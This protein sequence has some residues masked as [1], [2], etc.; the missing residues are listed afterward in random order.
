MAR[1][2]QAASWPNSNVAVSY[3]YMFSSGNMKAWD[4]ST[5]G[6]GFDPSMNLQL[7][8]K[9][10]QAGK[11]AL[12]DA[13]AAGFRFAA[14]KFDLQRRV[15]L[16]YLDLALADENLRIQQANVQLLSVLSQTAQARMQAGGP[17]QDL[18][19]IQ[20]AYRLAEND[21][22]N[23]EAQVRSQRAMLN[24]MLARDA[25]APLTL[26]ASLPAPRPVAAD[27]ARLIAV[28]VDQNP[29]LAALAA[30]VAGRKDAMELARL[31]YVPDFIPSAAFTGSLSQSVGAMVMLPTNLPG[32]RGA[33]NESQAMLRS[34]EAVSRQAKRDR[35]ASFVAALVL[36]RNSERQVELYQQRILP[37]AEQALNSSRQS[38]AAGTVAFADLIDSQRTL[39]D[40][41]LTLAQLHIERE[42]QLAE[43]ESLAGV[44]IE[45]LAGPTTVPAT[46]A[47]Q[48]ATQ[49]AS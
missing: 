19:K 41:R 44:D 17:Q 45:T 15:L 26:P 20:I 5:V 29:E 10:Q 23:L 42:R 31:R 48:P 21:L 8:V 43:L 16:G 18:L 12:Q 36:M 14:M 25:L 6:A 34:A 24:G 47:S 11:V 32:I 1:I 46:R 13:R 33:I 39:L 9:V 49:P 3:S 4:R 27:D 37:L 28:A 7:P 30:Q 35:T 22:A 40:V 38:Y 2:D